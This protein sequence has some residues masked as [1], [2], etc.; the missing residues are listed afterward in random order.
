MRIGRTFDWNRWDTVYNTNGRSS[1]IDVDAILGLDFLVTKKDWPK[2]FAW[3]TENWTYPWRRIDDLL[4]QFAGAK[5]FSCLELNSGYWQVEVEESDRVMTAFVSRRGLFEF[6]V[7]PF[8]LWFSQATFEWSMETVLA[9]L[10]WKTCLIYLDD[11]I[12]IGRTFLYYQTLGW[13]FAETSRGG[14]GTE[15]KEV[16]VICKTGR[17]PWSVFSS[18]GIQ[19]DPKKIKVV[20]NWPKLEMLHDINSFLGFY[21]YYRQ[22]YTEICWGRQAPAQ[23]DWKRPKFSMDRQMY[24]C[25]WNF[26]DQKKK[27]KKKKK[28]LGFTARQ[29]YFTHFE[30]SIVMWGEN[31]R[32]PRKK[33]NLTTS[34]QNL[35]HLTCDP[36]E[37]RTHSSEM[38][39]D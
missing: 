33:K 26:E 6:K 4:D 10:N 5:W 14:S 24:H 36:N 19:T 30:Q 27:K 38:T 29:D 15:I 20:Q 2:R 21:S 17:N 25:L 37:A 9:G 16:S 31:G 23:A 34:K 28:Y 22:V 39:S 13:C 35:A 32:S 8:G 18:Q 1:D 7:M 12:V 3:I 11:I